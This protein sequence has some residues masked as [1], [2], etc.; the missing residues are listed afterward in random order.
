[1]KKIAFFGSHPV[2]LSML[3][4]LYDQRDFDA[5]LVGVWTQPDRPSGRGQQLQAN[6]I[7]TWALAR[8]VAV[9]QP[10]KIGEAE[11]MWLKLHDIDLVLVAAY[12][13][14]LKDEIIAI[15]PCGFVN[16][17]LSILPKYRGA[18]PIEG[19]LISGER[20]TGVSLMKIVRKMDAGDVYAVARV[21]IE[22]ADT[23]DDIFE[24][25]SFSCMSLL[26]WN[27]KGLLDK[28]LKATPQDESKSSYTRKITKEDGLL[29]FTLT[30]EALNR[31]YRAFHMWPGSYFY[32]ETVTI[33]CGDLDISPVTADQAPGMILGVDDQGRLLIQAG[34]RSVIAITHLQRPGG[35]MMGATDF[36]RGF[37]MP[38]GT[39]VQGG[40]FRPIV[41][42]LPFGKSAKS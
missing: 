9:L 6:E 39:L 20:E 33:K 5:K 13:H 41:G 1:M 2:A 19:A 25:M 21:T 32:Y 10:E 42:D 34:Q 40:K 22:D 38:K 24:K 31:C 37:H 4:Y 23:T 18:A 14:I 11:M 27:L 28:T 3:D 7:K 26:E 15:P 17:H 8:N 36:L 35:K 30:A 12:G 29:D 16:F